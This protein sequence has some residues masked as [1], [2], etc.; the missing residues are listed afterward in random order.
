MKRAAGVLHVKLGQ[1]RQR[2]QCCRRVAADRVDIGVAEQFAVVGHFARCE[3][4]HR[5]KDLVEACA[6][7]FGRLEFVFEQPV[8]GRQWAAEEPHPSLLLLPL[9][10][11]TG[12]VAQ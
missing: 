10:G 2:R 3:A 5:A 1:N 6:M 9:L 11:K 8:I 7:L 12:H 4:Q